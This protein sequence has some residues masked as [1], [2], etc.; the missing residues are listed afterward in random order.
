MELLELRNVTKH[1]LGLAAV[2]N[3]SME[4]RHGEILGLIGPNGAGKTTVFNLITGYFSVDEGDIF[5]MGSSIRGKQPFH[6]CHM[7]IGRTFQLGRP[8]H[9]ITVLENV[10]IG[11]F[12]RHKGIR[13]ARRETEK[14]LDMVG[15]SEKKDVLAKNL[16]VEERKK[17][18]LAKALATKPQLLLLDEVM[19]GLNEAEIMGALGLLGKLQQ[20]GMTL[21]IIEHV[22]SAIMTL[23]HRIVVLHHGEMI[24]EGPPRKISA[25]ERVISAYLGGGYHVAPG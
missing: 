23:C 19:A 20:E 24:S 2:N 17:I 18:E 14:I 9:G 7:G 22:M 16:N 21:L 13:E 11:A 25:D 10:L 12:N 3:L 15:L 4:V 6:I 8:F 5:F 1:F